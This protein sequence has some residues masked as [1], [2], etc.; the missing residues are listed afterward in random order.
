MN[1][2]IGVLESEP[3]PEPEFET[4]SDAAFVALAAVEPESLADA[5]AD[6]LPMVCVPLA[7]TDR[8][9][10]NDDESVRVCVRV[11]TRVA[12][13]LSDVPPE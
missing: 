7:V 11:R 4:E 12:V 13:E 2:C 9:E 1:V 5:E 10:K 3:D 8:L 6:M